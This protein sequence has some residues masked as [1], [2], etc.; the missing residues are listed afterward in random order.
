MKIVA[1]VSA[2]LTS[3]RLPGKTLMPICGIPMIEMVCKRLL[4]CK[5]IDKI[6]IAIPKNKKNTKL[7]NYLKKRKYEVFEGSEDNVLKR[8]YLAAKYYKADLVVRI[9]GDCPLIDAGIVDKLI[10]KIINSKKDY[11]TNDNP[12]TYPDG[13]DAEVI[14]FKALKKCYGLVKNKFDKEHVTTYV[15]SSRKFNII[16]DNYKHDFSHLRWVVDEK[17]D[18]KVVRKIFQY[19][20]P[21]LNFSWLEVIRLTKKKIV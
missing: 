3:K 20:K 8:F 21:R 4:F 14:T 7:K 1:V 2:R 15:R 5:K 6:V 16:Y 13:L 10:Y 9:T 11:I 17:S 18:L 12:R 19:F